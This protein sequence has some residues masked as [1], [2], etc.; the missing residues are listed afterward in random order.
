VTTTDP[1]PDG[2][3]E[4][5][6]ASSYPGLGGRESPTAGRP[7]IFP[8]MPC[9]ES[10]VHTTRP[11]SLAASLACTVTGA[12][13]RVRTGAADLLGLLLF[14]PKLTASP[15]SKICGC[16]V[17]P[18]QLIRTKI[19]LLLVLGVA[20]R[21]RRCSCSIRQITY[22]TGSTGKRNKN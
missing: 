18:S 6:R 22:T 9:M 15:V 8:S 17:A 16:R 21:L 2:A 11:L 20:P 14:S 7:L 5:I 3:V 12:A 1:I 4:S 19:G 13:F 10:C